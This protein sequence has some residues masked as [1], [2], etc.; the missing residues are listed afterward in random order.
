LGDLTAGACQLTVQEVRLCAEITES[1]FRSARVVAAYLLQKSGQAKASK[2]TVDTD[3]KGILDTLIDDLLLSLYRPEWPAAAL[4]LNVFSKLFIA[5][6][7][8]G[9]ASAEA[10]AMKSIALDHLGSIAARLRA[11]QVIKTDKELLS[12]DQVSFEPSHGCSQ[13]TLRSSRPSGQ[14]RYSR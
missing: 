7:E 10:T 3:F 5:T 14:T 9:S 1:C 13:L 6:L 11:V 8:D 2:S 12:L 4:Y